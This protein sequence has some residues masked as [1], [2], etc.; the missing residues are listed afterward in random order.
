MR[1]GPFILAASTLFAAA[2]VAGVLLAVPVWRYAEVASLGLALVHAVLVGLPAPRWAVPAFLTVLLVDAVRTVPAVPGDSYGWQVLSPGD[3]AD[4]P[5]GFEV[6][7]AACWAP[8]VAVVLL[9]I[10]WRPWPRPSR[11]VAVAALLTGFLVT[12]YA[13]VRASASGSADDVW[14][15]SLAV[16][17]AVAL[18]LAGLALAMV[19]AGTGDRL[20]AA[21]A[22]LLTV[23]ALPNID[24]SIAGVLLPYNVQQSTGLF[25]WDLIRPSLSLPQ[26]MPAL[27]TALEMTAYLLMVAGLTGRR[28]RQDA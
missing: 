11:A 25:G 2:H 23:V 14:T 7:L 8:I 1:P 27:T 24:S 28:S 17:P 15:V 21:G 19:L 6:A 10:A 4:V 18:G 13:A 12:G 26:P 3:A 22:L 5:S 9:L 20:A 16:L